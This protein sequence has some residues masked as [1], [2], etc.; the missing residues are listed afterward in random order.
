MTDPSQLDPRSREAHP[1]RIPLGDDTLVR[2]DIEAKKYGTTPRTLQRG[3]RHG[4]PY[5]YVGGVK[6]RPERRFAEYLTTR[7]RQAKQ[8]VRRRG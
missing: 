2:D 7:I 6:Y 5:I 1:E 3:D 8:P 4:A